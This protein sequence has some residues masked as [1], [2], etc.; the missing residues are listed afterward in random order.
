M[1]VSIS[2]SPNIGESCQSS[3][4][5]NSRHSS[6]ITPGLKYIFGMSTG[7]FKIR[8]KYVIREMV[9]AVLVDSYVDGIRCIQRGTSYLRT[10]TNGSLSRHL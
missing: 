8:S 7:L 6:V 4:C 1:L 3:P 9:N 10:L 2:C 5:Q